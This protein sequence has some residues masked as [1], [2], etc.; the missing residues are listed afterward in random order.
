MTLYANSDNILSAEMS[1][2]SVARPLIVQKAL[3][4][5]QRHR[6]LHVSQ[7]Y[8]NNIINK[9]NKHNFHGHI[10]FVCQLTS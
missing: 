8:S 6:P 2:L 1:G 10:L 4:V 3:Y 7:I 9:L 5:G